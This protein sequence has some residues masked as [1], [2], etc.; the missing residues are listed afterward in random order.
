MSPPTLLSS[1]ATMAMDACGCSFA[2]RLSV[3]T[4]V[5]NALRS[6]TASSSL[7]GSERQSWKTADST[8]T[9][10]SNWWSGWRRRGDTPTSRRTFTRGG[11]GAGGAVGIAGCGGADGRR[12]S[13]KDGSGRPAIDLEVLQELVQRNSVLDPVEKLLDGKARPAETGHTAHAR[14]INP[15]GFLKLHGTIRICSGKRLHGR[16]RHVRC[17]P[18]LRGYAWGCLRSTNQI[19]APGVSGGALSRA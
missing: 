12:P 17:E 9:P 19:E 6:A 10:S 8:A 5:V 7:S 3:V 1:T 15:N 2:M 16:S 4:S 14:G 18:T 11:S 13:T